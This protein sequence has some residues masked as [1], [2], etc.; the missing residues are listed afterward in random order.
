MSQVF[1]TD[2]ADRQHM[3]DRLSLAGVAGTPED[4]LFQINRK[5][6]SEKICD[7]YANVTVIR[8]VY[9]EEKF[10]TILS[11]LPMS[12]EIMDSHSGWINIH[13]HAAIIKTDDV[14][15]SMGIARVPDKRFYSVFNK[16]V[17]WEEILDE[18]R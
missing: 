6:P 5:H 8:S 4:I 9:F 12:N 2:S 17:T 1:I 11:P 3:P 16:L 10:K 7:M 13:A 14:T 15:E 18:C